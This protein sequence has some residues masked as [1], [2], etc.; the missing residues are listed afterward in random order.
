MKMN[1]ILMQM[2]LTQKKV[3]VF[4][5][6]PPFDKVMSTESNEPLHILKVEEKRIVEQEET[7]RYRHTIST[8]EYF[9]PGKYL[10]MGRS[11]SPRYHKFSIFYLTMHF[12]HS[13]KRLK[14][15]DISDNLTLDKK[16]FKT[17]QM[18]AM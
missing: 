3:F 4:V 13:K 12:V 14:S 8:G 10:R 15:V 7:D 11:R 1:F 2:I 5:T 18:H 9:L 6:I 16:T 17:V